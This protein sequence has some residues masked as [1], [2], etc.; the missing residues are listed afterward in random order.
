M[1]KTPLLIIL[2][3]LWASSCLH[4]QE[5]VADTAQTAAI[6]SLIDQ[7]AEG[8]EKKDSVLLDRILTTELDQ[9]VSSGVWRYGKQA[10]LTS[11]VQSSENNPGDRRLTVESVRFLNSTCAI[12][13]ARYEIYNPD[14]TVRKM[15]STFIAVFEDGVW[16]IT[17]IRNMLPSGQN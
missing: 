8:R 10:S 5:L 14:G 6:Y 1:L 4:A 11:M 2:L 3:P 12:A 7:Y 16:K 9:L 13:D 15:W 17:A